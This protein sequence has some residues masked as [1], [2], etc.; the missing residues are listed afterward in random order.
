MVIDYFQNIKRVILFMRF[1]FES[2]PTP[3]YSRI[4][5]ALSRAIT[6]LGHTVVIINPAE[7]KD[8][9]DFLLEIQKNDIDYCVINTSVSLLSQMTTDKFHLFEMTPEKLVFIHHD[10]L[11]GHLSGDFIEDRISAFL[12]TRDRS[13]H[14][15]VEYN[16]YLNLKFLGI[17][18]SFPIFHASEFKKEHVPSENI[19]DVSFVGHVYPCPPDTFGDTSSSHLLQ[20]DYWNRLARLDY[21]I[22]PSAI[23]FAEA[24]Y[25]DQIYSPKWFAAKYDYISKLHAASQCFRGEVIKRLN[26]FNI[27][28]FGGDT[29]YLNGGTRNLQIQKQ[30]LRYH[31]ATKNYSDTCNIYASSS[32]NL[33]ITSLQFDDAVI[34]R[35]IDVGASGGFI[36]TDWKSDLRKITTV[37]NEIS[38]H[39]IDELNEKIEYYLVKEKERREVAAQF[40]QDIIKNNSYLNTTEY[41]LSK[42]SNTVGTSETPI[43]LDLGCGPRKT[44]GFI[45]VDSDGNWPGVDVTADLTKRFPYPDDSVD[46]IRAHDIIE[47]LPD[48]I[49]TMNELWRICKN[50]ASIDIR[51][52]STDGRG[53]FQDPTHISFWNINSFKYYCTEFPLYLELCRSYGFSGEFKIIKIDQERSED[54]V[55]HVNVLLTAVKS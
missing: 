41:I 52:P 50:G 8:C 51:V 33:N 34:N 48:R 24:S 4:I 55:I 27:D 1:L 3:I 13:I 36:L 31:Q 37:H 2:S 6:D 54:G 9:G 12:R 29:S 40:N 45:G 42:L 25:P 7:Y 23:R 47:H 26:N 14:F 46:E 16:D 38:Y 53:A 35:V 28:I 44:E 21:L 30:G 19:F 11:T 20:A 39:S 10:N 49:H 15:C 32:I 5:N 22:E 17:D 43:R 18:N